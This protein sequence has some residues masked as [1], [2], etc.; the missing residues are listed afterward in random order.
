MRLTVICILL[1]SSLS[2]FSANPSSPRGFH[3]YTQEDEE[4]VQESAPSQ[5]PINEPSRKKTEPYDELLA[6]RKSL[7]NTLAE[8]L[9]RPSFESTRSYMQAQQWLNKR[10]QQFVMYWEQVLLSNPELDYTLNS[11]AD[12]SAIEE[13]NREQSG[14]IERLLKK[15]PEKYGILFIYQGKSRVSQRFSTVL[16]R[17]VSAYG[18]SVASISIDGEKLV[19]FPQSMY[20]SS[21]SVEMKIGVKKKYT[22]ALFLVDVKTQNIAPLSYGFIS[23]SNLK[24]R[25]LD[26]ITKFKRHSYEGLSQGDKL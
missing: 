21:E 17:F 18:F 20:A 26:I 16:S 8:A 7:N 6:Q 10:N 12:N 13:R 3:W 15:G 9:L 24:E 5:N 4:Q 1:V 19:D 22:P 23:E 14:L 11:P 25:Y 2:V